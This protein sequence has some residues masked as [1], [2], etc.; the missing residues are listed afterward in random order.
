MLDPE[1]PQ[2][3]LGSRRRHG[4]DALIGTGRRQEGLQ[5]EHVLREVFGGFRR[6]AQG[7]QRELVGARRAAEPEVDAAGK[8]PRQR[9]ELLGDDVG[10]MVGQHDAAGADADGLRA[11]GDMRDDDRGRGAGDARHVVMLG[12]PD[13]AIAPV[14]GMGGEIAGVVER[15]ARIGLFGDADEIED[16]QCSHKNS[17]TKPLE[18]TPPEDAGPRACLSET[19]GFVQFLP[20]I[21]ILSPRGSIC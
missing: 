16:R 6:A 3:H 17:R 1:D 5:L 4:L 20:P 7:A 12:H 8:Q 14:L 18:M 10:R 9:A 21:W 11:G 19:A 15:A 2:R 13:A